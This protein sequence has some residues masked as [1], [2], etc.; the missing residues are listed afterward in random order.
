[1]EITM[2]TATTDQ[3]APTDASETQ[4]NAVVSV[5]ALK[6]T[7]RDFWMRPKVTALKGIDFDVY[8]GDVF[9]LLGPNGSGKST[10]F[11]ILLGLLYPTAGEISVLGNKPGD[12]HA[13]R[14][15]GFLPEVSLVY[16]HLTPLEALD[17]YATL[18]N[19]PARERRRLARELLTTVQL[20]SE[21]WTRP[22]RDLSKGMARRVGLAQVLIN[23]PKLII[24]DEP[25]SGLDPQGCR[26]MKDLIK[27]LAAQGRTVI[28]SSHMLSDVEDVCNRIAI[29]YQ[30]TTLAYGDVEELLQHDQRMLA[31]WE[32]TST[33]AGASLRDA[34]TQLGASQI[35]IGRARM[36]LEPFFLDVVAQH[37]K[38][39]SGV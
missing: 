5:K 39:E 4:R 28:V 22:I 8:Q 26:Q 15:I 16:P 2:N 23:D 36:R 34:L 33:E 14:E 10:T 24:L 3:P 31:E 18:F 32:G 30:G 20:Q 19:I 13:K 1:M 27:Q 37:R 21:S 25:T 11:K 9:G 38:R 7:F 12:R 29:L 17:F 6:K 35:T